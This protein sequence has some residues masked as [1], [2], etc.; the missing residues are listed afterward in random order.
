MLDGDSVVV[1]APTGSGKTLVGETAIVAA[2]A[3]GQKAIYTT[4]LKALSNQKLREFQAKFGVRRVGLKTGDVDVNAADADVVV[5]TTEILRN[6]LYPDAASDSR[7]KTSSSFTGETRATFDHRLDDVGVV[8]LDE[9][10]YLAD[11]N[12]GTCLLYTSPSPR[13]QRGSRMPSSA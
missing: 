11:A 6:M 5:M 2:L 4:P 8:I 7:L 10:H 13:D 12:R 1:S 3:R 9:V